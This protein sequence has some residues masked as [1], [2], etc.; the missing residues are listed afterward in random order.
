[1]KRNILVN[2]L[3]NYVQKAKIH[4]HTLLKKTLPK[5]LLKHLQP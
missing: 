4:L 2:C 3:K 1:M 5:I